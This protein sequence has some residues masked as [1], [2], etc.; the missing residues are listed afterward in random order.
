MGVS[1]VI[2]RLIAKKIYKT[3]DK[4]VKSI[5]VKQLQHEAY[6]QGRRDRMKQLEMSTQALSYEVGVKDHT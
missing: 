3:K 5:L 1:R 4:M 2:E 6:M